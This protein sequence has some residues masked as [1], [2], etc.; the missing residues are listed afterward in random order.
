[1]GDVY[2]GVHSPLVARI[3]Q[4]L[5]I[6][7]AIETGTYYGVGTLQLAGLFQTVWT[8]EN[9]TVLSGF[10]Q[11]NYGHINNIK[12]LSGCSSE[13]LGEILSKIDESILF[14]LDAHWFPSS[15]RANFKPQKQSAITEEL[16]AIE[17]HLK[18][19]KNSV[20]M[21]DDADMFLKG[22]PPDFNTL[23]FPRIGELMKL[24]KSSLGAEFVDVMDDVIIAG[25][26]ILSEILDV[27]EVDRCKAGAP[28]SK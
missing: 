12:F 14:F 15:Y 7:N 11:K 18:E 16:K 13:L 1:M 4:K 9:D 10:A 23:D 17:K 3:S 20:I 27:Y 25:P 22:L 19:K 26:K 2:W 5:G 21:I 24:A 28:Y 8:I 6:K